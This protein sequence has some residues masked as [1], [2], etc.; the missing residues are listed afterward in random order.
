MVFS[1]L[2]FGEEDQPMPEGD[3]VHFKIQPPANSPFLNR[4]IVRPVHTRQEQ[5]FVT[6]RHESFKNFK[7][8]SFLAAYLIVDW[9]MLSPNLSFFSEFSTLA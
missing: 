5:T 3:H 1:L 8:R 6:P 9:G 2:T 4:N 7:A